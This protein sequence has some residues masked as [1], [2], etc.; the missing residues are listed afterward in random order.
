MI[1][2]RLSHAICT[3]VLA[4]LMLRSGSANA[5]GQPAPFKP[6]KIEALV[7][8]IALYPDSVLSQGPDGLHLSA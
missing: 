5:Q 3:C 2:R 4:G 6:E 8:P 1:G 7:A